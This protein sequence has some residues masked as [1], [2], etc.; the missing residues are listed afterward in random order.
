MKADAFKP[1]S[2]SRE[3]AVQG[4]GGMGAPQLGDHFRI[5]AQ[6]T[7]VQPSSG[8]RAVKQGGAQFVPASQPVQLAGGQPPVAAPPTGPGVRPEDKF[9]PAA[10]ADQLMQ[11]AMGAPQPRAFPHREAPQPAPQ[12]ANGV[13]SFAVTIIGVG[14]DGQEYSAN[15]GTADFPPGLKLGARIQPLG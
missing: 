7:P 6:P 2:G 11:P 13:E 8:P 4:N 15:M 10:A 12:Q 14:P 5:Q 9:Q 3:V 1:A